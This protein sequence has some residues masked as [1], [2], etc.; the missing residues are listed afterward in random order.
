MKESRIKPVWIEIA[1]CFDE[2]MAGAACVAVAS[3]LDHKED[4][5][6]HY[7]ISCVCSDEALKLRRKLESVVAQRDA[8]SRIAFY[9]EPE[10]FGGAFEIRDITASTYY[11]LMLHRILPQKERIIYADTDML[12]LGSLREIWETGL[13][14][15]LL[16]GVKGANNFADTWEKCLERDY[17]P[18]L[19]GL[20]KKYVNA[21]LILMNLEA[22]RRQRPDAL[23]KEMSE[24]QYYYQDQDILNITC[25]GQIL[26]LKPRYNVFAHLTDR[27]YRRFVKEGIYGL[28]ECREAYTD[29]AVI[30]Y[31]GPK[32]WN[33]QGVW[34]GKA[35]W[36]YVE[37]R[38]DLAELFDRSRV[39]NRKTTG[40][41]G[42][43]NRHLPEKNTDK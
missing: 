22:I 28:E 43:I 34:R 32:P 12:F 8:E 35:W 27:E 19:A 30:H 1:F 21:G 15:N 26:F 14:Q 20:E 9:R 40:L 41:L 3:L 13:G 7:D 17:A 23:W 33:N 4:S 25:K 36:K 24:K 38:Q 42:R 18:E 10:D 31:T 5:D 16:A 6:I 37:S 39:P 29:P 11:R 2:N